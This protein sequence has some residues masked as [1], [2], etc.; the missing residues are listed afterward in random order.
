MGRLDP[1]TGDIKLFTPVGAPGQQPYALRFL[2]D[3]R[4][5]WFSYFGS[6]KIATINPDTLEM[7][8]YVLPDAKTKIRRMVVTSDDMIW[9]GDWSNGKL[10]RFDPKTGNTKEYQGP[11]GQLAQPYGMA[12]IDDVIWYTESNVRPNTLVRFDPK[13]EKFQTWEMPLGG[14]IV[15]HMFVTRDNKI[16]MALSGV[17]AIGLVEILPS[18]SN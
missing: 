7:K 4:R 18:N 6:N 17:S 5:P 1:K 2:S 12:V 13:T 14:G 11:S 3:G 9:F 10:V 15:R 16:A 8:E